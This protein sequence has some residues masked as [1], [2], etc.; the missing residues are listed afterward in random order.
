MTTQLGPLNVS[1]SFPGNI[2]CGGSASLILN[3]DGS[4]SFRGSFHDSGLVAYNVAFAVV[5][6]TKTNKAFTFAKTGTVY[7]TTDI[8]ADGSKSRDFTWNDTP[9]NSAIAAA[10]ADLVAGSDFNWKADVHISVGALLEALVGLG[11]I[12]ISVI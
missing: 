3:Q 12:V 11:K 5:I 8:L 6:T 4:C 2:A 9:T 7:G 1:I 10:W